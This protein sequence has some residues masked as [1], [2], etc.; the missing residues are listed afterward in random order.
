MHMGGMQRVLSLIANHASQKGLDVH[1][2]CLKAKEL[3]FE[4]LPE[5]K[6]YEPNFTYSKGLKNK[7]QTLAYLKDKLKTIKPDRALCFS[8][9]Y[10]PLAIVAAKLAKIPVFISDR[11]NPY[12]KLRNSINIWRKI[13]YPLASGM[14]A[15]TELAKQVALDKSYNKNIIVVPNPLREISDCVDKQ[16]SNRI[17]SVGRL[18]DTKRFDDLINIFTSIDCSQNWELL[19]L[20]DGRE[21]KKLEKQ[22]DS[23]KVKERVKLLGQVSDVDKYLAKASIFAFTSV[24]E[25]FPNA[26]SEAIAFPLPVIAYDCPAGPADMIINDENGFLIPL[27]DS[28]EF[29]IKL[30]ALM[31][32]EELR[33]SFTSNVCEYRRKYSSEKI[34]SEYLKFI[35]KDA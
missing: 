27:E 16:Y 13:T 7:I 10:N 14:I 19:I 35:M 2:I 26:L 30:E 24:S 29:K 31:K 11:S 34:I 25:G 5:I 23:L 12:K 32:S 28:K 4:L 18:V 21:R 22:I 1:I 8:E 20:G 3:D 9:V 15:Q 33:K 17:I 6:I